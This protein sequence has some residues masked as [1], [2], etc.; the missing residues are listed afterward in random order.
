MDHH[1][2]PPLCRMPPHHYHV[3]GDDIYKESLG[4]VNC[5]PE[6]TCLLKVPGKYMDNCEN[7][8]AVS[9]YNEGGNVGTCNSYCTS[10]AADW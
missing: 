4:T 6:N 7:T 3:Q 10:H 1:R 5:K 8:A 9:I 2:D